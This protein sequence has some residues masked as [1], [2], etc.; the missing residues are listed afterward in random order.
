MSRILYVSLFYQYLIPLF[1]QNRAFIDELTP[2]FGLSVEKG[3]IKPESPTPEELKE[4]VNEHKGELEQLEKKYE[5][6][7]YLAKEESE[8]KAKIKDLKKHI[9]G[10]PEVLHVRERIEDIY[11][12]IYEIHLFWDLRKKL[13]L[14]KEQGFESLTFSNLK[15]ELKNLLEMWKGKK[16]K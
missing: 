15:N 13:G 12:Q 7:D 1:L 2:L 14:I 10:L 3:K 16:K 4:L 8:V 6:G 5:K 11:Q 9:E